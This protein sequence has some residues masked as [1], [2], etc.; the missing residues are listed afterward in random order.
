MTGR[1]V[2]APGLTACLCFAL[3][4]ALAASP[5]ALAEE[6]R[7]K[8]QE[9]FKKGVSIGKSAKEQADRAEAVKKNTWDQLPKEGQEF[10]K[11]AAK[12]GGEEVW[13]KAKQSKTFGKAAK[14]VGKVV[15]PLAKKTATFAA[16]KA[17]PVIG[18]FSTGYDAGTVIHKFLPEET[19]SWIGERVAKRI[20]Y[21]LTG[22]RDP[23]PALSHT[24]PSAGEPDTLDL[25]RDI[26]RLL[27]E[28]QRLDDQYREWDTGSGAGSNS[29]GDE[30]NTWEGTAAPSDREADWNQEAGSGN[31]QASDTR[32][33]W[34]DDEWGREPD[35]GTDWGDES[36]SVAGNSWEETTALSYGQGAS[37]E[38]GV[39]SDG[40][41]A[42]DAGTGWGGGDWDQV[43]DEGTGWD[44]ESTYA[45][46][47]IQDYDDLMAELLQEEDERRSSEE[48][49]RRILAI[50]A[51]HRRREAERLGLEREQ[52]Q[53]EDREAGQLRQEA[54][55]LSEERER[56]EQEKESL[57]RER[58]YQERS[59]AERQ[60]ARIAAE[61][62]RQAR[63]ARE[64][65]TKAWANLA[66][67]VITGVA[68]IQAVKS[69]I[70]PA[71]IPGPP[72]SISPEALGAA[73]R[74]AEIFKQIMGSSGG[75]QS[76]SGGGC[77]A[78]E[79]KMR[80]LAAR[81]EAALREVQKD[82][83]NSAKRDAA[84]AAIRRAE[85]FARAHPH[86]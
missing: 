74:G 5:T 44:D 1:Q 68:R 47:S 63:E 13:E 42:S 46:G 52:Q 45:A 14:Q 4:V 28:K 31:W 30:G 34:D 11:E 18:A 70:D 35:E 2:F 81:A 12:E 22:D 17:N 77:A 57:G 53:A 15:K 19:S 50:D 64:Q 7:T 76:A 36:T 71:L 29:W 67:T 69:G 41:P 65:S 49:A 72:L 21:P 54:N 48:E 62:A 85:D 3:L 78:A 51:E 8:A 75:S 9:Y 84:N 61:Q 40:W 86:C 38:Q 73:Q 23:A 60:S 39:A 26:T 16:K 10:I 37:W 55:L 27:E 43:S 25:E 56:L 33:G 6:D 79:P 20:V 24:D 32:T 83:F 59:A 80:E 58:E 66:N 82:Q